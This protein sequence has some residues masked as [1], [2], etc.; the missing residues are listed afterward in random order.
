MKLLETLGFWAEA[1]RELALT[2][3]GVQALQALFRYI[4]LVAEPLTV[5]LLSEAVQRTAPQAEEAIMTIAE[6]LR[7]EGRAEG[8]AAL[9][10]AVLDVFDA[11]NV[12]V[13]TD[14]RDRILACTDPETLAKWLRRAAVA[15]DAGQIFDV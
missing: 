11:R 15:N 14:I 12:P 5:E 7:Q 9:A 3:N 1:F 8:R 10:K 13:A 2:R 4:S 6:Q